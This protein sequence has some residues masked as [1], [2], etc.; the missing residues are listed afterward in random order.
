[1]NYNNLTGDILMSAG[2]IAYLGTFTSAYRNVATTRRLTKMSELQIPA[3]KE[4]NLAAVIGYA[5]AIRQWTI[6]K[7]PNDAVSVGNRN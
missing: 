7:L 6:D 2:I 3:S 5:V 4:L 1:M